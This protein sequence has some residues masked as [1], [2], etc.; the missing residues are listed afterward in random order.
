MFN[1][2]LEAKNKDSKLWNRKLF[3][4]ERAAKLLIHFQTAESMI[5][6]N[7]FDKAILQA[8]RVWNLIKENGKETKRKENEEIFYQKLIKKKKIGEKHIFSLKEM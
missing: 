8:N 3:A 4:V 2:Q 1:I 6:E 5:D 7:R